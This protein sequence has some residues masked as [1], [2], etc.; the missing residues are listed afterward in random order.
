[1]RLSLGLGLTQ[2]TGGGGLSRYAI[3]ENGV[4]Y[5]PLFVWDAHTQTATKRDFSTADYAVIE[6]GVSYPALFAWDAYNQVAVK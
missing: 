5:T 2:R 6:G 4:S 1:M 3:T